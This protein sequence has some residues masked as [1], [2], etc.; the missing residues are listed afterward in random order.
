MEVP[1]AKEC[2]ATEVFVVLDYCLAKAMAS[3][4]YDALGLLM[5]SLWGT[6]VVY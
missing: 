1:Y 4:R 6:D 5:G 3:H 2:R